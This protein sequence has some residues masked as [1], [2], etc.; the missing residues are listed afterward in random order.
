[1]TAKEGHR[2]LF[3]RASWNLVDQALSAMTN[4]V[5]SF[6]IARNVSA[7][8]F[9][10]FS[11]AFLVF[12][13]IIGV[14]RALVGSPLSISYSAL[15]GA[16]RQ[17][18]AGAA[19]GAVLWITV[20]VSL[21]LM[22]TALLTGG[23]A[24]Q[25]WFVLAMFMPILIGQDVCRMAFFAWG[26]PQLATLNDAVW[27]VVQF[28]LIAAVILSGHVS[29][30]TMVLSWGVAAGVAAILGMLQLRARPDLPGGLRWL[31]DNLSISGYLL[32]EYL[33]GVGTFQGG[34]L[35]FGSFLGVTDIGSLRAAEVLAGP[36]G[37][38]AIGVFTFGVPEISRRRLPPR[39]MRLVLLASSGLVAIAIVYTSLLMVIPDA[40][41]EALLG[42]TW[43]GASAV[44]LPVALSATVSCGKLG[45]AILV[46]GLGHASR[47]FRI[48]VVL[49]SS[50][51][52]FMLVGAL[53]WGVQ[54]LAWGMCA[55][56]TV[57]L[58]LWF[59]QARQSIQIERTEQAEAAESK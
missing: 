32:A 3:G 9:G 31:R 5:M 1:M 37:I 21:A 41:G 23:T 16:R 13:L 36:L 14:Q 55:S 29:A 38:L 24:R 57:I 26:K 15:V 46:Y 2:R 19:F 18:A 20:P 58:P 56:Q 49:A 34:I 7:E 8:E 12:S 39:P 50:A 30:A 54:G 51:A 11:V 10:Q 44:L 52:V 47:T 53:V 59:R 40:W 45:P 25:T 35:V 6:I 22:A 42:D 43:T 4:F 28:A 48:N 33:L 27:T 17:H